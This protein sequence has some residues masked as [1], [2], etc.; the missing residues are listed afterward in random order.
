MFVISKLRGLH[1]K[2][3]LNA[4]FI[5]LWFPKVMVYVKRR[6]CV[7]Y[8]LAGARVVVVGGSSWRYLLVIGQLLLQLMGLFSHG[9]QEVGWRLSRRCGLLDVVVEAFPHSAENNN[10][11]GSWCV[12]RVSGKSRLFVRSY[13]KQ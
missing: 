3:V 4:L 2:L 9:R 8:A 12:F 11:L 1:F 10:Q 7:L 6:W 5:G 13:L